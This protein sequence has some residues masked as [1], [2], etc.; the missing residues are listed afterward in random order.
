MTLLMNKWTNIV[1]DDGWVHQFAKTLPFHFS[2]LLWNNVMD[3]W[4]SYEKSLGK[5]QFLQHCKPMIPQNLQEMTNNNGLTFSV[6]DS[7]P[8]FIISIQQEN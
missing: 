1:M 8:R 2:N 7:I 5:W 4:N 3:N 6:G